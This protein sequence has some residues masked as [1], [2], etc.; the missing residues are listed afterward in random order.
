MWRAAK[1]QNSQLVTA[2]VESWDWI[3]Y[4]V[5]PGIVDYEYR[6][7]EDDKACAENISLS[8][9]IFTCI[10]HEQFNLQYTTPK[11]SNICP[12]LPLAVLSVLLVLIFH[13][14]E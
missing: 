12:T 5:E 10:S 4:L 13:C 7:K 2:S 14:I 1:E 8:C 6:G 9:K 3:H 11:F